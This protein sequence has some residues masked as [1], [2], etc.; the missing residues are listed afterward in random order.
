MKEEK[1]LHMTQDIKSALAVFD[2]VGI[3]DKIAVADAPGE[4]NPKKLMADFESVIVFVEGN[5]D[6]N[7]A[8]MGGFKD[9]LATISAQVNAMGILESLGYKAMI[10]EG[11]NRAVSLVRMG[12][13]AGVGELSPVNSLVVKGL[14]LTVTIGAI[15]TN[16]PLIPDEQVEGICIHCDKCLRVCPIRDIA[17]AQGDLSKCACGK[18]QNICPV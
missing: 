10:I 2:K 16:A 18:C 9:Y 17:Y 3:T 6:P 8:N 1:N 12:I 14:G 11:C 5:S 13:A 7:A 15:I 4:Y